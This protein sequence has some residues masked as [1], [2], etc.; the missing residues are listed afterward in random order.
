MSVP[1]ES[2]RADDQQV[3]RYL[4]GLLPDTEAERLDEASIADDDFAARLLMV[5][6]DLIDGYVRG[7][8][9]TEMSDRFETHYLASRRRR[10]NVRF[11]R[12]FLRAIDW[13]ARA[14]PRVAAIEH[15]DALLPVPASNQ[16]R[17]SRF[18]SS[19]RLVVAATLFVACGTLL[20]RGG[21][22]TGELH[23]LRTST[24]AL[25]TRTTSKELTTAVVLLPQTRAAS[26]IATVAIPPGADR[27]VFELR[28]ETNDF[29]RYRVELKDPASNELVWRSSPQAARSEAPAP[30]VFV[31][32]AAQLL[33]AQHYSLAVTATSG[34]HSEVVGSYTV[35]VV[36]R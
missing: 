8:L 24:A 29:P 34:S 27:V 13:A 3:A 7:T 19:W 5:E 28:L 15:T 6:T 20:F 18:S 33:R 12:A 23:R 22:L 4:L 1:S 10:E 32:I 14:E 17:G 25:G 26:S 16:R 31:T 11:A 21:S 9:D 30:A 35:E 2:G 36:R